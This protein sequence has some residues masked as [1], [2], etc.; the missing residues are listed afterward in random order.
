MV[1]GGQLDHHVLVAGRRVVPHIQGDVDYR[2]AR[3]AHQ[4][5]FAARRYL[6]TQIPHRAGGAVERDKVLEHRRLPVRRGRTRRHRRT[7][8]ESTFIC[9]RFDVDD[10]HAVNLGLG[11]LHGRSFQNRRSSTWPVLSRYWICL[12]RVWP[13]PLK[14]AGSIAILSNTRCS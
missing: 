4:F 11:V 12:S 9:V 3:A 7:G 1:L 2:G 10:D 14:V 13:R 5:R 8:E 6:P